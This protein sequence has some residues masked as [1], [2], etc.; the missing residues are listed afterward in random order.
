MIVAGLK[1]CRKLDGLFAT[2]RNFQ[3]E[4][5]KKW[6]G[7]AP[8]AEMLC[9]PVSPEDETTTKGS[10]SVILD[11]LRYAGFI[12]AGPG[13]HSGPLGL[14]WIEGA[15]DKWCFLVGDG[16]TTERYRTFQDRL[17]DPCSSFLLDF[18]QS[19]VFSKVFDRIAIIPGDL[20]GGHF[21]TLSVVFQLFYGGFLQPIQAALRWKRING[22]DVTQTYQQCS[23]LALMVLEECER[24]LYDA[25]VFGISA[26]EVAELGLLAATP[27]ALAERLVLMFESFLALKVCFFRQMLS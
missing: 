21:H 18:L 13:H 22:H 2:A 25:F 27:D 14:S 23:R 11:F 19:S 10:G 4:A 26:T 3:A 1:D 9:L 7:T 6:R 8:K 12:K 20:H 24:V 15:N 17:G 5:V 16:L